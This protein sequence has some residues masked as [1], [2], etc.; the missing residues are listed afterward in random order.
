MTNPRP[1]H[2]NAARH[3]IGPGEINCSGLKQRGVHSGT[4]SVMDT[5]KVSSSKIDTYTY[6]HI[7]VCVCVYKQ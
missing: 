1:C 3:E 6:I 2:S 5:G 7:Y 4:L